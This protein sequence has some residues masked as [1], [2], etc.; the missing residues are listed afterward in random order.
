VRSAPLHGGSAR[1]ASADRA[2]AGAPT[3]H[4]RASGLLADAVHRLSPAPA[5]PGRVARHPRLDPRRL[6]GGWPGPWVG[7]PPPRP[8][9]CAGRGG[10][11][12][13]GALAPYGRQPDASEP[14]RSWRNGPE[15]CRS[16]E[17]LS[18]CRGGCRAVS[19]SPTAPD[20][21]CPLV[22][23]AATQKPF[24]KE[25]ASPSA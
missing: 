14:F 13:G 2:R 7:L 10:G 19:A 18:L 11:P 12:S 3:S 22:L 16:C 23:A 8:R 4:P 5:T 24:S 15:P 9:P 21:E 6:S 20:P 25:G 1:S 17:Y